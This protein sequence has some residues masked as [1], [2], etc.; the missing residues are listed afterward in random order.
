MS[1]E[2]AFEQP[3]VAT[4]SASLKLPRRRRTKQPERPTEN[5]RVR[6]VDDPETLR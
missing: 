5:N 3:A 6:E 2:D 1:K 4:I